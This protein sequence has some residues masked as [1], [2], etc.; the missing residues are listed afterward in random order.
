MRP[1]LVLVA[2]LISGPSAY[3]A[4]TAP[5]GD[6]FS[7]SQP[8]V[9]KVRHISLDLN[10]DFDRHV[11]EGTALLS[12]KWATATP[13]PLILDTK[14]LKIRSVHGKSHG[15]W[16][17]CK[18]TVGPEEPKYGNRLAIQPCGQP[19]RIRYETSPGASAL[20]WLTPA[21]TQGKRSPFLFTQSES[22]EARSWVPLQDRPDV[23]FT[24]DA[25]VH[26]PTNVIAL[27]GAPNNP[28]AQR[29][30]DYYFRMN[31]P[32]PSY[33]LALVVGDVVFRPISA[34]SGVWA[35]PEAADSAR[36]EFEDAEAMLQA[37][38][39][40]YGPY[41]WGRFDILVAPPSFPLG[42]ME[43]P[44]LT[45]ISP[46]TIVG[47]K[48]LVSVIAHELAHSWSGNLVTHAS[49]RDVWLNEGFTTYVEG[50]LVERLYGKDASDTESVIE[51]ASLREDLKSIPGQDQVLAAK[52]YPVDWL[53]LVPY[54]KGKWFLQ[55][56]ERRVGREDL[57]SFLRLW[58]ASHKF[59][60]ASSDEF[61]TF[62]EKELLGHHSG[63]VSSE[64]LVQWLDEPGIPSTAP[65]AHSTRLEAVAECAQA[66]S[67]G[68]LP[69]SQLPA[70]AWR[71]QEWIYFI[72]ALRPKQPPA[73]L[74]DLDARFKL[75][76][77][78]NGEIAMRWYRLAVA[79]QYSD[80]YPDIRRFLQRVGRPKLI[81]PIYAELALTSHGLR[82]ARDVFA[83][84]RDSYHPIAV[85]KIEDVLHAGEAKATPTLSLAPGSSS[86]GK[87][88]AQRRA[89]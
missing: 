72:D 49:W 54:V 29:T 43:N 71:S 25:R 31:R 70:A 28:L 44:D 46:T 16:R 61:R 58:F 68:S 37:A 47:D 85:Q 11:L 15:T 76:R 9:V 27:M 75:S 30:G 40:L 78:A 84:A 8:D 77:T 4:A 62:L 74:R 82:M 34:R 66:W 13:R 23:R 53:S 12:L 86:A 83:S 6:E 39:A 57:D 80:A 50:R 17:S 24:Y 69:T 36:R 81:V 19:V 67:H 42:G 18:F 2:V 79:S 88:S 87:S 1:V 10:V 65:A 41:Q 3:A 60:S 73:R 22:L 26:T 14:G 38:E 35:E 63:Q 32:I 59:E 48:S 52:T 20:Q 56:L 89:P 51:Q 33:L 7:Y 45:F 5:A 21:M 55:F 64:E